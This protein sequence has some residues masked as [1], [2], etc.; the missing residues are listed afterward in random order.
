M[1]NIQALSLIVKTANLLTPY[2][3]CF[4]ATR[5]M[6]KFADDTDCNKVSSFS[7]MQKVYQLGQDWLQLPQIEL[8]CI[9]LIFSSS[10]TGKY[11]FYTTPYQNYH[12]QS[13]GVKDFV[14]IHKFFCFDIHT[15]S[16]QGT[17]SAGSLFT[18]HTK[19]DMST[20]VDVQLTRN[21]PC[22]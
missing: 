8:Q 7:N 11:V 1:R 14:L 4:D 21:F 22:M 13:L 19:D 20:S 16:V 5:T 3:T 10:S 15:L 17:L 6:R 9:T 12:D 2:L 18:K